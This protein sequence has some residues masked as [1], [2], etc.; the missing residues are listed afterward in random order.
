MSHTLTIRIQDELARW[1][2]ETARATGVPQGRI[3]REQLEQAREQQKK[4][5]G[6]MRLAGCV[7]GPQD[8]ST[9]K[10]FARS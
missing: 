9:R 6:F 3:V 2:A 5:R 7:R 10:G 1:L 8:L 4:S